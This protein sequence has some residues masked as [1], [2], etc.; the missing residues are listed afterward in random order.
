VRFASV[1]LDF[2]DVHEFMSE[3]Q[4]LLR[5]KDA[6]AARAALAAAQKSAAV[7]TK[8]PAKSGH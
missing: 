5:S 1:Y 2:K 8:K 6:S 3:L 7:K 4:D